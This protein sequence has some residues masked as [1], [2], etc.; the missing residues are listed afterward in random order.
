MNAD[1]DCELGLGAGLD[2]KQPSVKV[3]DSLKL[4][5]KLLGPGLPISPVDPVEPVEPERPV[6]PFAP[7]EPRE[8]VSPFGPSAPGSP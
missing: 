4:N 5:T 2:P 8:P 3:E 7:V 1:Q 6:S